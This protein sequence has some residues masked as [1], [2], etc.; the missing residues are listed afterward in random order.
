MTP[1][2]IVLDSTLPEEVAAR[3]WAYDI[4]A[5]IRRGGLESESALDTLVDHRIAAL[6]YTGGQPGAAPR[7]APMPPWI[8]LLETAA[9]AT[10]ELLVRNADPALTAT[11]TAMTKAVRDYEAVALHRLGEQPLGR[12]A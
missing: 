12:A 8:P 7:E 2:V 1:L 5:A 4:A 9:L 6:R 3:E 11:L 10:F